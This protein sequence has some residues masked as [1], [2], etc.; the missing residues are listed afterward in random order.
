MTNEKIK[1]VAV[2][3]QKGLKQF[4]SLPHNIYRNDAMWVSPLV[5][6]EL[7]LLSPT[8]NPAFK[9]CDVRMW[10]A[11]DKNNNVVGR[12]ATII[13]QR[14]RE[15]NGLNYGRL[16]RFDCINNQM[17]ANALLSTAENYLRSVGVI[18]IHG[19]LGF[20]NLD[21]QGILIDGFDYLPSIASEYHKEYY[22]KLI[23]NYGYKKQIDWVE[24]R[25][26][27][28]LQ[29]PEKAYKV[30]QNISQ[31]Y[32]LRC[33]SFHNRNEVMEYAPRIFNL[34]NSSF[35]N[36]FGTFEFDEPMK[37]FYT[38]KYLSFLLPKYIKVVEHTDGELVGFIVAMPSLSKALQ[39]ANGSLWPLGWFH[40]LKAMHHPQTI[41]LLLTGVKPEMQRL[42]VAALLMNAIWETAIADGVRFV[43]TTS[44]LEDNKVAIQMWKSFEHIQHKRKRCYI[45]LL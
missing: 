37:L 40:I 42:G 11:L 32:G 41:D 44:M 8:E 21:H 6:D 30:A 27:L 36:L 16:S 1:I 10:I 20:C 3:N 15:K 18:A 33:K 29:L 7:Q 14:W 26:T 34:F 25:L 24:F 13:N 9:F 2:S 19:P 17:V 45:K 4:V 12:I 28:P 5:T 38:K 39:K 23:E 22:H 43:E 31:R 35:K